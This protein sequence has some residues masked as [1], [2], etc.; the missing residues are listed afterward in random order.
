MEN[1]AKF[2]RRHA[3]FWTVKHVSR[4]PPAI[5]FER[6]SDV[7]VLLGELTFNSIQ[8]T[9]NSYIRDVNALYTRGRVL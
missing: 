8:H 6:C 9:V 2:S 5:L 3:V 4:V 1:Y 7:S